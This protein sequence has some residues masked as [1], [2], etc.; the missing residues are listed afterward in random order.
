[1][2]EMGAPV[3]RA[4]M[5]LPQPEVTMT[6]VED[7]AAEVART[8]IIQDTA[9]VIVSMPLPTSSTAHASSSQRLEDDVVLQF[10][11]THHLSKLTKPGGG[12]WT[13]RVEQL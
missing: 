8:S 3:D 7:L 10:D 9:L 6:M 11:A 1:M 12:F 13:K 4:I 2:A 5:E